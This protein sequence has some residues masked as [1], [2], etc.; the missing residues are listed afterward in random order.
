MPNVLLST[1]LPKNHYMRAPEL[2]AAA[3]AF[4][5]AVLHQ[6]KNDSRTVPTRIRKMQAPEQSGAQRTI[7]AAPQSETLSA[8]ERLA[9]DDEPFDDGEP[10]DDLP[11]DVTEQERA[12]IERFDL[13]RYR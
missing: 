10:L 6:K 11:D 13:N 2:H 4:V 12:E 8:W 9:D 5:H 7:F 1:H 3:H